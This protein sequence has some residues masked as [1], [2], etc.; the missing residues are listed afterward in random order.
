ML[1][2]NFKQPLSHNFQLITIILF[3]QLDFASMA[4]DWE[5]LKQ[6]HPGVESINFEQDKS[7]E[8]DDCI[9]II[10]HPSGGELSFSSSTCIL[11]SE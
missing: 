2:S 1:H 4:I 8:N 7:V 9:L 3:L 10:Q 6:I 11:Y 5:K